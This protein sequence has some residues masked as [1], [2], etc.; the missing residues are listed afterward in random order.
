MRNL[1][2]WCRVKRSLN[3]SHYH[4]HHCHHNYDGG[5][6]IIINRHFYRWYGCASFRDLLWS[7]GFWGPET[8]DVGT[9]CVGQS[10]KRGKCLDEEKHGHGEKG[11]L[12]RKWG[13]IFI[14]WLYVCMEKGSCKLQVFQT[15]ESIS[16]LN[17]AQENWQ[18]SISDWPRCKY[19]IIFAG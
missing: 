18:K 7:P 3:G 1:L 17:I 2:S 12:D 19:F 15:S 9:L 8:N 10:Q 6:L 16:S 13:L 11:K 14:W 5:L 4:H